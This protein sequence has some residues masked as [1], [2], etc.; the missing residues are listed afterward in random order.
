MEEAK[1][2]S[3]NQSPHTFKALLA[4][5]L[6]HPSSKLFTPSY[7]LIHSSEIPTKIHHTT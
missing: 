1:E 2:S 7:W 6:T 4:L 5:S 3:G